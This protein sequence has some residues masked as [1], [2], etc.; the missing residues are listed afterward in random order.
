MIAAQQPRSARA[1]RHP[2]VQRRRDGGAQAG[3]VGQA[4]IVVGGE[5]H[6]GARGQPAQPGPLGKARQV[7]PLMW[8]A[9]V[10]FVLYF[11]RGPLQA[12]IG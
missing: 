8:I 5:I 3:R 1:D 6:A 2:L 10:L 4:Q 7:H 9:T 11:I 12:W